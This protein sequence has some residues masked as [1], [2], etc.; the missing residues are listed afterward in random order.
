MASRFQDYISPTK[1]SYLDGKPT[2]IHLRKCRIV[3]QQKT[4]R[5]EWIFE[6]GLITVGSLV[7][8]CVAPTIKP[9]LLVRSSSLSLPVETTETD[10]TAALVISLP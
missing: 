6:H 3:T 10:S 4:N 1:I 8:P 9:M 2:T 5:R 7:V